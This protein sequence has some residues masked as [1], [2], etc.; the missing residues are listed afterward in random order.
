M[1]PV[2]CA[3]WVLTG[4]LLFAALP[5]AWAQAGDLDLMLLGQG[6]FSGSN[7][8]DNNGFYTTGMNSYA[9][10]GNLGY[11]FDD[12][13]EAGLGAGPGRID[14]QSCSSGLGCRNAS[15]LSA[16]AR[17]FARYNFNSGFGGESSFAGLQVVYMRVGP[18][19]GNVWL[20]RPVAGYR[21]ALLQDW[22]LE[23]SL[24]A[25]VPVAGDTVRF[26]TNY[27]VQMGLVIPLWNSQ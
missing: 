24:G 20:L 21:F 2:R 22:S 16:Q 11:W 9:F 12:T 3:G 5:A 7:N 26:P 27:D 18:T 17:I 19:L 13:W 4:A 15:H 1:N 8:P 23:L 14:Y 6:G 10:V 25:G